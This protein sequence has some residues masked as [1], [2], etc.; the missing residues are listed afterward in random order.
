MQHDLK[1][2][3]LS[4]TKKAIDLPE[5]I[6]DEVLNII[7]V[8]LMTTDTNEILAMQGYLQNLD[9][10]T[11]VY[12]EHINLGEQCIIFYI[13]NYG[14]CP[15]AIGVV[16][17]NFEIHGSTSNLT[18]MAYEIFPN[19]STIVSVGITYSIQKQ[20]KICDVL[21][22]SKVVY[23][24]KEYADHGETITQRKTIDVSNQL[25]KVFNQ[26]YGWPNKS[27]QERLNYNHIVLPNV[28]SGVILSGLYKSEDITSDVIGI[29]LEGANLFRGA[30]QNMANVISIKAVC[31]LETGEYSKTY[32]PTAAL[33]AADLIYKCLSS[34]Q[35]QKVFKGLFIIYFIN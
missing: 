1:K 13:G 18:I 21:V 30:L 28:I 29:D 7:V 32:Q 31:D 19:L 16:P 3:A 5:H 6:K 17:N 23:Y 9:G 11:N 25:I 2:M 34:S 12:K 14:I 27:I 22:S 15:A 8:L 4:A 10:H 20:V 35:A 24:Y 33:L 26:P